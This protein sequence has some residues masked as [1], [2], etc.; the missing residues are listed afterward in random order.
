MVCKS[1]KGLEMSNVFVVTHPYFKKRHD[2]ITKH[3]HDK[4]GQPFETVGVVGKDVDR[5]KTA[6]NPRLSPGQLGCALAHLSAYRKM[7]ENELP[8]ALVLEDDVILPNNI[9]AIVS[10]LATRIESDEIIQLNNWTGSTMYFSKTGAIDTP[11]GKLL[12]PLDAKSLGSTP[13]YMIGLEAARNILAINY[14]VQVTADNFEY[15][16]AH[17]AFRTCRV[18]YPFPVKMKA[19]ETLIW[20][21]AHLKGNDVKRLAI[22]TFKTV[23]KPLRYLR[24]VGVQYMKR[25]QVVLC[26]HPSSM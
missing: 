24:R 3:I 17:G 5:R 21:S 9:N 12:L 22:D 10:D 6:L 11:N 15:F 2:Y 14:P 20:N 7:V 1:R 25:K 19:F 4:L 18:L 8:W 26:D 13:A 23:F 16:Y